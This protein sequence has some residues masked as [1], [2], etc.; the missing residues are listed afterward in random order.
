MSW[1]VCIIIMFAVVMVVCL[2]E[3][4]E[5]LFQHFFVKKVVTLAMD[6]NDRYLSK[7]TLCIST[8]IPHLLWS[9][10]VCTVNLTVMRLDTWV[11]WVCLASVCMAEH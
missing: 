1:K 5:P 7:H 3:L 2:Q 8:S 4:G 6:K 11:C 9:T 10:Q